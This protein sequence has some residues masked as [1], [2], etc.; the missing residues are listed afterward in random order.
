[1]GLKELLGDKFREDL[2]LAEILEETSKMKLVDLEKGEYVSIK[3]FQDKENEL[4]ALITEKVS[5]AKDLEDIKR[6]GLT[7]VEK[8]KLD[9]EAKENAIKQI[10]LDS[11]KS[12]IVNMFVA[13]GLTEEE[14]KDYI[15]HIVSED[16]EKS[17]KLASGI[18][19]TIDKKL[20]TAQTTIKDLETKLSGKGGDP[21]LDGDGVVDGLGS[22]YAKE[23][24][25]ELIK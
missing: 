17:E 13:K 12:K 16:I 1:M 5:L 3:K 11:N 15:D 18:I 25:A 2:T 21:N 20:Q 7:D 10:K 24:N 4:K 22:R 8:L 6:Q 9:L 23:I 14:Y 19:S